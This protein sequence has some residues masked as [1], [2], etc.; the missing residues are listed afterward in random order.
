MNAVFLG[1]ACVLAAAAGYW[2]FGRETPRPAGTWEMGSVLASFAMAFAS[3]APLLADAAESVV[4]HV[5]RLISNSF[6]LC[7]ATSVLAV[8]IRFN[9]P[10]EVIARRRLRTRVTVLMVSVILLVLLFAGEA[11]THRSPRMYGLYLLVFIGALAFTIVDLLRQALQ[12]AREAKRSSVRLGF[13]TAAAGCGFAVV[14]ATY[15]TVVLVSMGTG[16]HLFPEGQRCSSLITAP[17]VFSV[18]SPA[19]AVL[20]IAVGLTLPAVL[21]PLQRYR[22]RRWEV[23]SYNQL[24][25]LW[26]ALTSVAPDIVLPHDNLDSDF[27]L[28]RRVVE[29]S[30]GIL[31]LQPYRSQRVQATGAQQAAVL[32]E[33]DGAE[34]E[35]YTEAVVLK[36]ALAARNAEQRAADPAA[37][38]PNVA[39]RSGDLESEARWLLLVAEAFARVPAPRVADGGQPSPVGA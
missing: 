6:S 27:R 31:T 24:G 21:I 37:P 13:R 30:D 5:A 33:A 28:Q 22:R 26:Q 36:A 7:A 16:H 25:P 35:A 10:D 20:L 8:I 18:T 14:Y 34:R 1:L 11:L 32:A 9:E 12:H 29:I 3:Y 23:R 19:L 15:K 2:T 39:S 17:C 38:A 4:P